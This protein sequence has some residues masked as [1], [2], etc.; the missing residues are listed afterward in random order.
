MYLHEGYYNW[1]M[2]D[3]SLQDE[4][5]AG[6]YVLAPLVNTIRKVQIIMILF[7]LISS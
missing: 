5:P 1:K 7:A 3:F 2:T 6:D 4:N